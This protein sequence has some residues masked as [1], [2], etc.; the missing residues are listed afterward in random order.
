M[1]NL[2]EKE[3][4]KYYQEVNGLIS[5]RK[6]SRKYNTNHHRIKKILER[7]EV[8]IVKNNP[9]RQLTEKHKEKISCAT[10]GRKAWNE[11]K[12]MSKEF[13]Y[14]NMK[15]HLKYNISLKWLERFDN[16][17]RLKFLNKRIS[18]RRDS[19]NFNTNKY[20]K[21]I[22]KFYCDEQFNAIYDMWI[23]NNKNTYYKPS[24]DHIIPKSKGGN[25]D[26]DNLQFLTWYENRCKNNMTMEEWNNFKER[27]D[28]KSNLFIE[29]IL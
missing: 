24:L 14:K 19:D 21:F 4:C 29:N 12:T 23:E 18:R 13:L 11:G 2:N 1:N 10:K 26:V 28:T 22:E 6:M 9:K 7:N 20:K 3:I 15:N 16:I 17:E 27:T 8:E 5:L 25:Y